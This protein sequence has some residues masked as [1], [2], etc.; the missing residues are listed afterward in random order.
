[1]VTTMSSNEQIET[2]EDALELFD[3]AA[4]RGLHAG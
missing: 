2:L 3:Q 4:P 1:M